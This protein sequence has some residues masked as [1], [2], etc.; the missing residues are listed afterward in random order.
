MRI[1]FLN[2]EA[3]LH[4]NGGDKVLLV[5]V[6][7]VAAHHEV[8][9]LLPV[10]GPLV[11]AIRDLGVRCDVTSY[12]IVR[13]STAN[14][15]TAARYLVSLVISIVRLSRHIR[16]RE[17]D[18]VYSNSLGVVQGAVLRLVS[19]RRRHIWHIHDMIDR[20]RMVNRAYSWL[21]AHGADVA[22][23]VSEAARNHLPLRRD[24][25]R[26]VRNGI[27]PVLPEPQFALTGDPPVIGAIGRFNKTKGHAELVKAASVLRDSAA[28]FRVRLVGGTYGGDDT[29]LTEVQRLVAELS[30]G[31]I[32][33]VE[34]SV[35]DVAAVYRDLD[36]V[37][38]PSLLL[39][40]FPT[41][42][43]EA[44]SAGKPV[45]GYDSGGL[46]EMLGDATQ[47]VVPCGDVA[48]LATLLRRM[49]EDEDWRQSTARHQYSRYLDHFT[50]YDYIERLSAA[51]GG[52]IDFEPSGR[53][54][55]AEQ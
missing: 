24:N 30:L 8:E 48:G 38:V 34:G 49:L 54:S 45:V 33:S 26:V 47:C 35:T 12:P 40:S 13:R 27:P 36:V 16:R 28:N 2:S 6:A 41:V 55:G 53:H 15:V 18:L 25:L 9:V 43:L 31:D 32:V 44:M 20:P 3:E 42:G 51:L 1:L 10:T 29:E 39:D 14:P 21:V 37:V 17:I 11:G 19:R 22:I 23:C 5:T 52:V 50:L 7:A 46:R 4:N